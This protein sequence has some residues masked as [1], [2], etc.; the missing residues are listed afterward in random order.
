MIDVAAWFD[1]DGDAAVPRPHARAPWSED[2]LHGR[3]LAGLAARE[4]EAG[5]VDEDWFPAWLTIDL[6]RS[7]PTAPVSITS[8]RIRDGGASSGGRCRVVE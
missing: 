7:P 1:L 6:V 3:L 5:Q 4:V 2:M 8:E